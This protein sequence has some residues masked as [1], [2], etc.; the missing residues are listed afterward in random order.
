MCTHELFKVVTHALQYAQSIV[1]GQSVEEI[2]D[3]AALVHAAGVLLE[4][5]HD[6]RFVARGQGGCAE[7]GG[8]LVIGF[9]DLVE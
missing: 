7:D 6:L 2:L 9:E 8:Q 4:L 3:C 5:S 1:L